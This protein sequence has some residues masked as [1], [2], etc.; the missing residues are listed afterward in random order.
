[1]SYPSVS[2]PRLITFV[3][4]SDKK[5]LTIEASFLPGIDSSSSGLRFNTG[6][7]NISV[8]VSLYA[9][10]SVSTLSYNPSS[11]VSIPLCL[12]INAETISTASIA[13][14]NLIGAISISF[15]NSFCLAISLST[16]KSEFSILN[17]D[18]FIFPSISSN[19]SF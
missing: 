1:M 17:K 9:E 5:P 13:I 6:V 4:S 16:C 2:I 19:S 7:P 15:I 11:S 10:M 14:G 3:S 12:E 18:E 8:I